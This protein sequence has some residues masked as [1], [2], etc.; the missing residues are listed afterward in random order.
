M[1]LQQHVITRVGSLSF[2]TIISNKSPFIEN[3]ITMSGPFVFTVERQ[4]CWNKKP[5]YFSIF[6]SLFFYLF[7]LL[8]E[9]K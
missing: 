8:Y 6:H 2:D 5:E 1:S 3:D 7:T 4:R 9:Q